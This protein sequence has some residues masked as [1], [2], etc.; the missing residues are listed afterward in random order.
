MG[1][2]SSLAGLLGL[3]RRAGKA[4]LG[5]ENVL[6]AA[7]AHKARLVLIAADASEKTAARI[8]RAAQA[9]NAPCFRLDASK[10]E[11]GGTVG[12]ASCAAVGLTDVGLAAAAVKKLVQAS[13]ERYGEISAHLERKAA[14]TVR[15]RREKQQ[16][17]KAEKR[18]KPWAAPPR[19]DR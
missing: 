10:A 19:E 15:R 11:L 12:L 1:M 8:E 4:E 17:L 7:S 6:S 9:G 14:K 3:C 5:E 16:R 13:P 18:A 2:D